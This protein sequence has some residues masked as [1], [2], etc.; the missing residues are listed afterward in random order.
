MRGDVGSKP[1]Q[2]EFSF[3]HLFSLYIYIYI[4]ICLL[5][6]GPPRLA[7]ASCGHALSVNRSRKIKKYKECK[8]SEREFEFRKRMAFSVLGS[9]RTVPLHSTLAVNNLGLKFRFKMC[10]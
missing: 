5:R 6:H 8:K 1:A 3:K 9:S 10:D 7:F 2:G 4:A